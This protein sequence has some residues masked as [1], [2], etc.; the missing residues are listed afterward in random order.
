MKNNWWQGAVFYQIYPRSFQDSN[1][2]GVGDLKGITSRLDY[3]AALGVDAVWISPF[4]K[5]PMKDFGYDVSDY[6]DIDPLF[7]NMDD[8]DALLEK[9]H[10]LGLKIIVDM[11][12]SHT[13]KDH[14][15]FQES[16]KGKDNPKSDWYVWADA[17]PDGTPP[18][19]WRSIFGGEAWTFDTRRGQF[20]FHN[21]LTEQP[22]L[23]FH[24]PDVQDAMLDAC[25]FWLD[26][27]VDGFRLDVI[28]FIFH[29]KDLRNNPPKDPAKDGFSS[30]FEKPD[31]YNMQKHI[32]DKSQPEALE[33]AKRFRVMMDEYPDTMTLA[34]IGDDNFVRLAAAYTSGGDKY[35]TAY[36][37]SLMTG[38]CVTPEKI[39][40]ALQSFLSEQGDGW[41]SWAFCNH[42]V[43][44]VV[45]RWGADYNDAEKK[46]FAKLLIALLCSLKGTAFLYQGEEL[47][48]TEAQI[49]YEKIQDPW[50]KYLW[51]EWQG[52]DGCRTPMPWDKDQTHCAFT[53]ADEPWLPIPQEHRAVAEQEN[54]PLSPLT[55]TREF[56]K[57]RKDQAVLKTGD[58]EFIDTGNDKILGFLRF[59]AE[60]SLLCIFNLSD[61]K[62]KTHKI[63][64][65]DAMELEPFMSRYIPCGH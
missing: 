39:K 3:I 45:S 48:L 21:F 42:D 11:V 34:E 33:F 37:F 18:N 9:A 64:D 19:N 51:P 60:Q 12:M 2:D 63:Q 24:N 1:G 65:I 25:R 22:D 23:N 26:K 36:N 31:P 57:W 38:D 32:H 29:D 40:N 20:Y 62:Q 50:G 52:R 43:V 14:P 4:F 44:R 17:N 7:G 16:R 55:F 8:F 41:P 27:G 56:L 53:D 10:G 49:P 54:D 35:N 46:E 58:I 15:W 5:S 47:G 6:Y 59:D 61:K 28:N 13:S 30:Q